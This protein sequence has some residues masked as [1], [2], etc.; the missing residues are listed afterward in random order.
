MQI[1]AEIDNMAY[2]LAANG[3]FGTVLKD[4]TEQY[5]KVVVEENYDTQTRKICGMEFTL[6]VCQVLLCILT[7]L[8]MGVF[9]HILILQRN[10]YFLK[11]QYP[12]CSIRDDE[13]QFIGDDK[14]KGG[15]YNS[16]QCGF[17]GG[18]CTEF[19]LDYPN[20][21]VFDP[22]QVGNGY[23]NNDTKY[24]VE[25]CEYDGGDCCSVINSTLLGDKTCH[26]GY[27]NNG[28]CGYDNGDCAKLRISQL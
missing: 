5:Q 6:S 12:D 22:L 15:K 17:D 2:F 18:D 4:N 13:V 11:D 21:D 9:I 14:C 20:C 23:Y 3:Y 10:G 24:N 28:R 26:G 7:F 8:M 19:N 1:I 16:L 27:F 25:E